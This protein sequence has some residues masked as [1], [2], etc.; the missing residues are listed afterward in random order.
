MRLDYKTAKIRLRL[1]LTGVVQVMQK[2]RSENISS[3]G[4]DK[5]GTDRNRSCM[6]NRNS[7]P[8]HRSSRG[9]EAAGIRKIRKKM[10]NYYKTEGGAFMLQWLCPLGDILNDFEGFT[11]ETETFFRVILTIK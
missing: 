2:T 4:Q 1:F 3:Q 7:P 10:I 8:Q 9:R 11:Q 5:P 6:Q